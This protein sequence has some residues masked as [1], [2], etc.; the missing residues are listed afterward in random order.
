VAAVDERPSCH[1]PLKLE[2]NPLIWWRLLH[3]AEVMRVVA[4]EETEAPDLGQCSGATQQAKR[5]C[6]S[7]ELD[8]RTTTRHRPYRRSKAI[9][10]H[11]A[12]GLCLRKAVCNECLS[13]KLMQ[14]NIPFKHKV[15]TELPR[16]PGETDLEPLVI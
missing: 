12:L 5:C 10:L 1:K 8:G 9:K 4:S 6:P 13:D 14:A 7:A 15:T 11:K 16:P 3:N 2:P